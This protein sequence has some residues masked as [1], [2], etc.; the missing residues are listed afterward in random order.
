MTEHYHYDE[1]AIVNPETH[2]E[3]SDVNVRA[4]LWFFVIVVISAAVMYVG[5]YGVFRLFAKMENKAMAS[6][7]MTAVA[8]PEGMNMPAEPRLQPIRM[9]DAKG[10]DIPPNALT[11]PPDMARMRRAQD[12]TLASYGMDPKTGEVHIP[13]EEA[14]RLELQRGFGVVATVTTSAPPSTTSASMPPATAAGAD[15]VRP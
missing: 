6:P 15:G 10:D 4:L 11:P 2:H 8:R 12:Q 9:K 3:E 5:I 1:N 7:S 14:K 13:I